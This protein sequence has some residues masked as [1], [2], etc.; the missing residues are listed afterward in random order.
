MHGIVVR[1]RVEDR[2]EGFDAEIVD[3]LQRRRRRQQ[4]EV[5]GAFRQQAVDERGIDAV[6]REHGVGDALRR[7]LVVVEAGGAEGEVEVGDHRIQRQ[8]ARDRPGDVVRDGGGA[9]AALGADDG[10]DAADG[11]GLRRREQ[12]ADR[13]HHV[14]RVDRREHIVADAAA[15]QFAVQRD[16]VDLADHDHPG[17]GIADG[18]EL[19]EAGEDVGAALGLQDD[20]VRRRR[21][22]IGLDGGCHAAHLD[23]EMGL[24]ETAVFARRLHGGGGFHGF[25]KRLHRHTRRRR[26]VIV[27]V[28]RCRPAAVRGSGARS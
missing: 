19:V 20:H 9:D 6:R 25:A 3:P 21:G 12:V 23:L 10:D 16:V 2:I 5:V 17:T 13:A 27:R 18:G 1:K 26:N 14:Q 11:L 4:A 8:I 28:R 22:T 15:H 7:I 24:A